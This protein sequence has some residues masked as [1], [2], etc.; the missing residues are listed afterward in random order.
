MKHS[1][2][3]LPAGLICLRSV[4]DMVQYDLEHG[5]NYLETT[6]AY[7]KN[8]FNAVKTA[9]ALFIHRSTFL[10]R[11]ERIQTQFELNLEGNLSTRLHFL[12]SL[13]LGE[14]IKESKK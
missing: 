13:Y 2:L 12:L 7:V 1:T 4:W 6:T 11:L 14:K 3:E 10:Y 8:H 9:N 5:T